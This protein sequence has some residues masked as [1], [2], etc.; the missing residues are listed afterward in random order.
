MRK[1]SGFNYTDAL[2]ILCRDIC[3]RVKEFRNIDAE[4]IG[5]VCKN[6]RNKDSR[7]GCWASMTPL[8][9][10]NGS[11]VTFKGR[12]YF[13]CQTVY[14]PDLKT[15]LLYIFSVMAPRFMDALSPREKIDTVM[16]ELY[17]INP[18]FNGDVRRFPGRYWQHGSKKEYEAKSKSLADEWLASDPDPRIYDF[19]KYTIS[20]FQEKCGGIIGAKLKRVRLIPITEKEALRLDQS[21]KKTGLRVP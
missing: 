14:G 17:H 1:Q 5:Y 6:V 10:E 18:L 15:P 12:K 4:K 21:L 16:H 19:L 11:L 2:H 8:R 9:F 13:K 7:Y 20:Y 3:K